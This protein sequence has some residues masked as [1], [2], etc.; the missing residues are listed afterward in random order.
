MKRSAITG[1][2]IIKHKRIVSYSYGVRFSESNENAVV[3]LIEGD[4]H[5]FSRHL[6]GKHLENAYRIGLEL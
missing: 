5:A 4:H 1:M 2:I 3:H 6:D